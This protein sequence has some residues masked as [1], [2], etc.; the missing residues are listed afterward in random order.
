M[1]NSICT[2][3]G[4]CKQG[5]KICNKNSISTLFVKNKIETDLKQQ[6]MRHITLQK[7]FL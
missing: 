2:N 1:I 5:I 7:L 6:N 3:L 4:S